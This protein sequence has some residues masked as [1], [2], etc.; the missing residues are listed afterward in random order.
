MYSVLKYG[1]KLA[2][3]D[4]AFLL[5]PLNKLVPVHLSV[6]KVRSILTEMTNAYNQ[7]Q[8]GYYP[9]SANDVSCKLCPYKDSCAEYQEFKNNKPSLFPDTP[10]FVNSPSLDILDF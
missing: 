8:K 3:I 1:I 5:I 7:M 10:K 9:A 6:S 2:D 4:A